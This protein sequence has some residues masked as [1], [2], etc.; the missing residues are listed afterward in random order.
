MR[1]HMP[2]C[3]RGVA[4][5]ITLEGPVQ[6]RRRIAGLRELVN[7]FQLLPD[8]GADVCPG[9]RGFEPRAVVAR[10]GLRGGS[11][12]QG[13]RALSADPGLLAEFEA[14]L[15]GK[16]PFQGVGRKAVLLGD[17]DGFAQ[18]LEHRTG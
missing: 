2:C 16:H 14:V 18:E 10:G 13:L 12:C 15:A 4:A 3:S 17:G 11:A 1:G 7:L 6:Q 9:L 8:R 5:V